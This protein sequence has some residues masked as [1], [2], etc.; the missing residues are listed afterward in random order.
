MVVEPSIRA[1]VL[2]DHGVLIRQC[3]NRG[4]RLAILGCQTNLQSLPNALRQIAEPPERL[5]RK[6]MPT[7]GQQHQ[8]IELP[9]QCLRSSL[10]VD[11]PLLLGPPDL[12][13]DGV[14]LETAKDRIRVL[15]EVQLVKIVGLAGLKLSGSETE[16]ITVPRA[17]LNPPPSLPG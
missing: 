1:A 15:L 2:V 17:D 5:R 6:L 10:L 3:D 4:D 14:L 11:Q 8:V 13:L 12:P 16:G 9:E 7:P